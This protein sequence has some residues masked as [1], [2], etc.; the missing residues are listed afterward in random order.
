MKKN[1]VEYYKNRQGNCA[2][3]VAL[4]WKSKVQPE[5]DHHARFSG[6]GGGR[7]PEGLCG[8]LHA[9]C[10]LA[11]EPKK[12]I[13][14]EKFRQKAAGHITCRDIRRNRAMPCADC[15]A[16]AAELLEELT[17]E[18]PANLSRNQEN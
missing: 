13:L 18:T 12:E 9:A 6:S 7:A 1:A 10:E 2:Q 11:G 15:V 4:A 5:A 3:A 17:A 16:T 14:K 8:A